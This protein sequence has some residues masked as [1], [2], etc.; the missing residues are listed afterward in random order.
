MSPPPLHL[1][2]TD[3]GTFFENSPVAMGMSRLSDGVF[4]EVNA[5]FLALY[6]LTREEIIGHTSL[7]LGLWAHSEQRDEMVRRLPVEMHLHGFPHEYRCKSGRRGRAVASIDLVEIDGA[8]HML[9]S[10]TDLTGYDRL[11]SSLDQSNE[12]LQLA[13]EVTGLG[14]WEWNPLTQRITW[15]AQQERLF[16]I[17]TGSFGGTYEDFIRFVHPAV[18]SV[19]CV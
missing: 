15:S 14:I 1:S 12:R 10:I 16:G 19:R 9:G 3:L 7:E 4:V 11:Q 13:Q 5:A 6:E 2:A 8:P 17:P 18:G